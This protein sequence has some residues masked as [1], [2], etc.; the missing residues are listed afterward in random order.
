M[1]I[2]MN[3]SIKR[4]LYIAMLCCITIVTGCKVSRFGYPLTHPVNVRC[5]KSPVNVVVEMV[6][7][8]RTDKSSTEGGAC[9]VSSICAVYPISQL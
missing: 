2:S 4:M 8:K 5:V 7:D 1:V 9:Y 6:A 3:I